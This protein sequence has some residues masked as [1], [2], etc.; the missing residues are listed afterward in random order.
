M[1]PDELALAVSPGGRGKGRRLIVI[2]LVI[3]LLGGIAAWWWRSTAAAKARIPAYVTEVLHHGSVALIIT[4]TGNLVPTNQVIVGS[5][6][7]G[8]TLEVLAD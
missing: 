8:T 1:T 7:S 6:L 4:A 2:L 3:V 5:E